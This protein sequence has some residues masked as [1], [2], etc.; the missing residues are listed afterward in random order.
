MF[1]QKILSSGIAMLY[2]LLEIFPEKKIK[3]ICKR[4][5]FQFYP[6]PHPDPMP[7]HQ[8]QCLPSLQLTQVL[9]GISRS[10]DGAAMRPLYFPLMWPRFDFS[11]MCRLSLLL[12]LALLQGFFSGFSSFPLSTNFF[13]NKTKCQYGDLTQQE[14][15]GKVSQPK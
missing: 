15:F 9:P 11:A 12:V 7:P 4:N 10:T 8:G 14:S 13:L 3:N 2:I 6:L 1:P 5:I